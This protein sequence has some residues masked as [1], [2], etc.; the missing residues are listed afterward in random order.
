VVITRIA[1]R[2]LRG[3]LVEPDDPQSSRR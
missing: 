2:A 1:R 3:A